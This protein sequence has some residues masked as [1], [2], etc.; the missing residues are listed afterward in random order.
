[1]PKYRI[2]VLKQGYIDIE[3]GSP[4]NAMRIAQESSDD[5]VH[6]NND[7]LLSSNYKELS[8]EEGEE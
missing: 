8:L 1:M 7:S 2:F 4:W 3:A 6:W 5:E